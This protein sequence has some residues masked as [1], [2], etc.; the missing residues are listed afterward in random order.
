VRG[1]E[2]ASSGVQ[3][4][5]H[6]AVFSRARIALTAL[7]AASTF[8]LAATSPASA[9]ETHG[10]KFAIDGTGSTAGPFADLGGVAIHQ[11]TGTVYAIDR[12]DGVIDKFDSAGNPQN[13]SALG[14]SSL[15]VEAGCPGF[16]FPPL[17][18]PDGSGGYYHGRDEIAVSSGGPTNGNIYVT[19][20][21]VD[22]NAPPGTTPQVCAFDSAGNFLWGSSEFAGTGLFVDPT[23]RLWVGS[24]GAGVVVFENT[25][26]GPPEVEAVV[27]AYTGEH[28][29]VDSEDHIFVNFYFDSRVD[30]YSYVSYQEA[31]QPGPSRALAMDRTTDH[32]YV[33]TGGEFRE[34]SAY[35][36]YSQPGGPP[37]VSSEAGEDIIGFAEGIA[38]RE[39]TG[40]IYVSDGA[41]DVIHVF[42]PVDTFA[43]VNTG[44]AT[45][46]RRTTARAT[47][48]VD[49][50]GGGNVTACHVEWGLT[51][52]YGQSAPCNEGTP[53]SSPGP[54]T[55]EMTGLT[56]GTTYHYRLFATDAAGTNR[57]KD[58]TFAT[59]YVSGVS[60]DPVTSLDR[61]TATLNGSLDPDNLSTSYYFQWGLTTGYGNTAPT[62]PPGESVGSAPGDKDVSAG[63]TGLD[64]KTTYHYRIVAMNATGKT[65]GD[66][67]TFS[68]H[69]PVKDLSTTAPSE[70]GPETAVLNGSLDPDDIG[71]HYYFEWGRTNAY[72]NIT[73][74]LPGSDAGSA[75]GSKTVSTEIS[76]LDHYTRYH[77]RL[78]GVNGFGTTIGQDVEFLSAPPFLPIVSETQATGVTDT[79]ATVSAKVNPG[80][81]PT[82]FKFQYGTG[83]DY[84]N[85]TALSAPFA[86][87]GSEHT[88]TVQIAH[89]F[90]AT[91]YH[92]RAVATNFSGSV[93]GADITF[94]TAAP[95]GVDQV[96]ASDVTRTTAKLRA[97]IAPNSSPTTYHFDY[98][99]DAGYGQRTP[100]SASIGSDSVGHPVVDAVAGLNPGSV[101]HFR[102][103]ATNAF[104]TVTG[105]DQVFTTAAPEAVR[106]PPPGTKCKRGFKK[107]NGRCVK[108][109]KRHKREQ[110]R[111]KRHGNG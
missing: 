7:A 24:F 101:Y 51:K 89:L 47:G 26:S 81:G 88:V 33:T 21:S 86:E 13:F 41:K 77:Y 52:S 62:G 19:T 100:E 32:L 39:S 31:L 103:V 85:R 93:G 38:I 71:T 6:G 3:A 73:P 22:P 63:L 65:F 76:G 57:G 68:T 79:T 61:T 98:G 64:A 40:D 78:I 80:F 59:P 17:P 49:P 75:P 45:N 66:D 9:A 87:D 27:P 67:R 35:S 97:Q 18:A 36:A 30:R 58:Q 54:V 28:V 84:G 4:L 99:T 82:V 69:E 25:N 1:H 83:T 105:N 44:P 111:H 91:T 34:Y 29:A 53:Y 55:A 15:D 11:G 72:G 10:L 20:D 8:L 43:E 108:V 96:T 23:G 94:S 90:P 60:T 104:G 106:P 107:R 2:P 46:I 5:R 37:K 42:G 12:S 110:H 48:D 102:V 70:V 14:S 56:G 16:Q 74:T 92:L 50:D 95:P 109:K